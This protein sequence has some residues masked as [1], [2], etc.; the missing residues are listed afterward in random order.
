MNNVPH[1]AQY[2]QMFQ[3]L[4]QQPMSPPALPEGTKKKKKQP[5]PKYQ[6]ATPLQSLGQSPAAVDCP[7]CGK[8]GFTAVEYHSGQTTR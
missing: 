6:N 3:T 4:A 8:Q 1:P 5:E 2:Q 7:S